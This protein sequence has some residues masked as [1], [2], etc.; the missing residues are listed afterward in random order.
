LRTERTG[1]G[2]GGACAVGLAGGCQRH[3]EVA[4]SLTVVRAETRGDSQ[5]VD[6]VPERAVVAA[7]GGRTAIVGD[8]KDHATRDLLARIRAVPKRS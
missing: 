1:G 6:S 5:R 7:Y 3:R 2:S 4:K 8:P